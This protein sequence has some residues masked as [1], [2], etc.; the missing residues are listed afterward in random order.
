MK[1]WAVGLRVEG[2]GGFEG[3]VVG[4]P[5]EGLSFRVEDDLGSLANST[6]DKKKE[7]QELEEVPFIMGLR[8]RV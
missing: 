6:Q 7:L 8:F 5:K 1:L 4:G 2:F 3:V